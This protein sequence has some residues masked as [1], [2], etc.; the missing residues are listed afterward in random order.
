VLGVRGPD[1]HAV[2]VEHSGAAALE[3]LEARTFDVVISDM[4]MPGM[5]GWEL[6]RQVGL[7]Y[8]TTRIIIASGWGSQITPDEA[9]ERGVHAVVAKPYRRVD[10]QHA[11]ATLHIAGVGAEG[12]GPGAG[13]APVEE[14]RGLDANTR[15]S[16]SRKGAEA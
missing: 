7:R 8:P 3:R 10:I 6:M 9:R 5:D 14:G 12:I 16:A 4:G 11:I 1:G 13:V 15:R 2:E